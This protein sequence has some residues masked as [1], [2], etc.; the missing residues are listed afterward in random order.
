[1]PK[2][3]NKSWGGRN[4][5]GNIPSEDK[6]YFGK[7]S[8][9]CFSPN[10]ATRLS[11][12][13]TSFVNA[14]YTL[15]WILRFIDIPIFS[16]Q[17]FKFFYVYHHFFYS[18]NLISESKIDISGKHGLLRKRMT[19]SIRKLVH[20]FNIFLWTKQFFY[21]YALMQKSVLYAIL[22]LSNIWIF[23]TSFSLSI[24]YYSYIISY[25]LRN[26]VQN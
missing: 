3:S 7:L 4:G 18:W 26:H 17:F 21:S 2:K 10:F 22:T 8:I 24:S 16:V 23:F 13:S 14:Q 6:H 12:R 25:S 5:R 1:M 15:Q 9:F 19:I 20:F 11:S